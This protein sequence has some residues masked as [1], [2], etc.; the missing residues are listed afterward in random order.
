MYSAA[1]LLAFFLRVGAAQPSCWAYPSCSS[2]TMKIQGTTIDCPTNPYANV[3]TCTAPA[4]SYLIDSSS[5]E[6]GG[7]QD[8][9]LSADG[10][11]CADGICARDP[12][13]GVCKLKASDYTTWLP[14]SVPSALQCQDYRVCKEGYYAIND[15]PLQCE[16]CQSQQTAPSCAIGYSPSTRCYKGGNLT[17]VPCT[18]PSLLSDAWEYGEAF[19]AP[20]CLVD[21]K[22]GICLTR[23]FSM[24]DFS[25]F[26]NIW[27]YRLCVLPDARLRRRKLQPAL[28]GGLHEHGQLTHWQRARLRAV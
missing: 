8:C 25:P 15:F 11:G 26:A 20:S 2:S 10:S 14:T 4:G 1:L 21:S 6:A 24:L 5:G 17:C 28:Q 3:S 22:P 27:Y 9:C 18:S 13:D 16:Q 12:S 7:N 23:H 19:R